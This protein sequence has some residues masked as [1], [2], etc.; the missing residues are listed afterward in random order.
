MLAQQKAEA[1]R[2]ALIKAAQ[3][4][5]DAKLREARTRI[6]GE[7]QSYISQLSLGAMTAQDLATAK[8]EREAWEVSGAYFFKL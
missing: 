3:E 1:E 4:K 6:H 7:A 5:W 2:Q 8:A